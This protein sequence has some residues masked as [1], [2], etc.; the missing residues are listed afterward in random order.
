MLH[1]PTEWGSHGITFRMTAH[2]CEKTVWKALCIAGPII[3]AKFERD[4]LIDDFNSAS[5]K[6]FVNYSIAHHVTDASVTQFN[7][8]T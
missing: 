6:P 1:L 8:P 4:A 2:T 7:R 5:I 3:K